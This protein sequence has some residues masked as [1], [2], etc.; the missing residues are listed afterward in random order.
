MSVDVVVNSTKNATAMI[1]NGCC[2]YSLIC[3]KLVQQLNLPRFAI[4]ATKLVMVGEKTSSVQ[5]VTEFEIDV[6]GVK[7]KIAAYIVPST[8]EFD[9][10]LGKT[11]LEDV[12]GVVYAAEHRLDLRRY[13]IS[14]RSRE[15]TP[16]LWFNC[17]TITA[18]T[19]Q[20]YVRRSKK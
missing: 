16:A 12:D 5:E 19:F 6:G 11:W 1:D 18:S 2:T 4:S 3:E 8:Y 10:I 9:I 13:Q 20:L 17:A 14:I 7:R 15:G